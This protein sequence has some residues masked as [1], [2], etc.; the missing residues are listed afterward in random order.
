M[1]DHIESKSKYSP[2]VGLFESG[3]DTSYDSACGSYKSER[4]FQDTHSENSDVALNKFHNMR[5][6]DFIDT[7][8]TPTHKKDSNRSKPK[9][10]PK[11]GSEGRL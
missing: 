1:E 6:G 5:L 10:Q 9:N 2:L 4:R 3:S 7:I 8:V 11:F